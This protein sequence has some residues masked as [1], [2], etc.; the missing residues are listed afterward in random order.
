MKS[1]ES[2]GWVTIVV[3]AVLALAGCQSRPPVASPC[4]R[5]LVEKSQGPDMA[6]SPDGKW[7]VLW[8]TDYRGLIQSHTEMAVV[9]TQTGRTQVT[10]GLADNLLWYRDAL[11]MRDGDSILAWNPDKGT[12]RTLSDC[13]CGFDIAPSGGVVLAREVEGRSTLEV[14]DGFGSPPYLVIPT[15]RLRAPKWSPDGRYI[16]AQSISTVAVFDTMTGKRFDLDG[17]FAITHAP[18]WLSSTELLVGRFGSN[19]IERFDIA[20]GTFSRFLDVPLDGLPPNERSVF[21]FDASEDFSKLLIMTGA[22]D[23]YLVDV[24]CVRATQSAA[25]EESISIVVQ[26]VSAGVP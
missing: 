9:D 11:Y 10:R 12:V 20:S 23:I 17:N 5:R 22:Q 21:G 14:A 3:S 15:E 4:L 7:A 16:A 2:H 24:A 1:P 6:I 18:V 13:G 8:R 19:R 25:M 26:H